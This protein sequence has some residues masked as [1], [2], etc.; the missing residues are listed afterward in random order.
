VLTSALLLPPATTAII[1]G[2][3]ALYYTLVYFSF[4]AP[5]FVGH[6][7]TLYA[8]Y[9]VALALT[10]VLPYAVNFVSRQRIQSSSV[11]EERRRI[12]SEIH[13]G[14]CQDIYSAR[15]KVQVLQD[16]ALAE[17]IHT[18]IGQLDALLERAEVDART[19]LDRLRTARAGSPLLQQL[20]DCLRRLQRESRV[21][22]HLDAAGGEPHV[23][24]L[25]KVQAIYVCEEA[26]NNVGRH[27][28]AR[29][30][31]VTVKS[32]E[33][34]L[35]IAI[36]DDGRGMSDAPVARHGISVMRERAESLG[37]TLSLSSAP[38]KGTEVLLE[39][40]R[41]ARPTYQPENHKTDDL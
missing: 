37:G 40:P 35:V 33:G 1:A 22:W 17:D 8:P 36:A 9:L 4:P 23:D 2:V 10:A 5:E 21:Q 28:R 11:A 41:H 27:A 18:E 20:E 13:D 7:S 24:E 15:W 12:G 25:V 26:L 38:G 16:S 29:N 3:T 6:L 32:A 31:A 34:N 30:V 19:A 39:V 14:L